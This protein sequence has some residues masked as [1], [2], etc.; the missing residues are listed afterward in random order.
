MT[1]KDYIAVAEI[2]ANTLR[3]KQ[4]QHENAREFVATFALGLNARYVNFDSAKFVSY[5]G[6]LLNSSH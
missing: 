1:R 2:L 5:V 6:R 4:C 3:T